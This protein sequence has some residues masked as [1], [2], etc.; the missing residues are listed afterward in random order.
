MPR[1][2]LCF[3]TEPS[4]TTD[5][6][7]GSQPTC[8]T[9]NNKSL[10]FSSSQCLS[11]SQ[12]DKPEPSKGIHS[13]REWFGL[14][15]LNLEFLSLRHFPPPNPPTRYLE[16]LVNFTGSRCIEICRRCWRKRGDWDVKNQGNKN[17]YDVIHPDFW[18]TSRSLSTWLVLHFTSPRPC[19]H[20]L[21]PNV[22]LRGSSIR[23]ILTPSPPPHSPI[24]PSLSDF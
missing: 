13:L 12:F 24:S 4:L 2:P 11:F 16:L 7:E 14:E 21:P 22:G 6:H 10:S 5:S 23:A 9:I 15:N 20:H 3:Q 18:T 8:N 1:F 17:T 19:Y